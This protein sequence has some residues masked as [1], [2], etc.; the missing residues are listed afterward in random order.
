MGQ[1]H[2]YDPTPKQREYLNNE[3]DAGDY[4]VE[5]IENMTDDE[6][7]CR[8]GEVHSYLNRTDY[9]DQFSLEFYLLNEELSLRKDPDY[10]I[11]D[12]QIRAMGPANT[13]NENCM[14]EDCVDE[15]VEKLTANI[16]A[17]SENELWLRRD[18]LDCDID[19]YG[20]MEGAGFELNLIEAELATRRISA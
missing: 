19:R 14:F 18:Q 5:V 10:P 7:W 12:F 15:Q 1:F 3:H 2:L 9:L 8:L 6:L 16:A 11:V 13:T 20:Y 4:L 17:M